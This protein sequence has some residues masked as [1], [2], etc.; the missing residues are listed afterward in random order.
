MIAPESSQSRSRQSLS[1]SRP[2][3]RPVK[4]TP[5]RRLRTTSRSR[6]SGGRSTSAPSTMRS[7]HVSSSTDTVPGAASVRSGGR[8]R[9]MVT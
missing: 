4:L 8:G 6:S 1:W 2:I 3:W 5:T 7:A 9:L